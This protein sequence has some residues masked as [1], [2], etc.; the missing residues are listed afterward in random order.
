MSNEIAAIWARVSTE[1]Q[2]TLDSQAARSKAELEK[3]GYV[4][5]PERVIKVDWT[6]LDLS[7]C[8]QFQELRGW[9]QRKEI[10][11]LGIFDRDRLNAIGLQR[12]IFISE[13]KDNNVELVI[14]QGPPILNE[15]EGQL[16]ELAMA[17]GKQRQVLRAQQG[18]RDALRERATVKGLS[19]NNH[20]PFGYEFDETKTRLM[21]NSNWGTRSLIIHEYLRGKTI[22]GVIKE[23][24]KRGI[25][26]PKGREYWPE[27]TIY[28]ILKNS[29][30][31]GVYGCE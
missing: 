2:Q 28:L 16:V 23:L 1:P 27:P 17:I 6:S 8:P 24:Q 10:A 7:N 20:P 4:V 29:V 18:S 3:R 13:C 25:L 11:A 26:S 21:A 22:K 9:I 12:L 30:N 5:P 31:Y 14:C 19:T 15:L